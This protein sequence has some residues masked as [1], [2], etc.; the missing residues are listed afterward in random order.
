MSIYKTKMVN[1]KEVE[2]TADEISALEKRDKEWSDGEYDRLM[3]SIRQ[4]RTELLDKTEWT[5]NN[6]NQLTDDKKT[7]WK[8]W[9]QKLRDITKDVDTV[10]KAK[11]VTMPEKPE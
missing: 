1:N 8:V 10:D 7:E 11:A 3:A 9:R 2:L 4:E 6:D 5:V